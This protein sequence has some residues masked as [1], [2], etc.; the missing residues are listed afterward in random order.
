METQ[1]EKYEENHGNDIRTEEM[2]THAT[3]MDTATAGL[4]RGNA[5]KRVEE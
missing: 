4:R 2:S 1:T 3:T 5:F